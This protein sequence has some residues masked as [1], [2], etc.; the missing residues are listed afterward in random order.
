L[1]ELRLETVAPPIQQL[2]YLFLGAMTEMVKSFV[3]SF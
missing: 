2:N 1:N 3:A